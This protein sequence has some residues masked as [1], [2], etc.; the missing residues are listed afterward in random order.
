MQRVTIDLTG[1]RFGRLEVIEKS[2]KVGNGKKKRAYWL[3]QCD[4]GKKHTV[5][6]DGLTSGDTTSCGCYSREQSTTHGMRNTLVYRKWIALNS[7]CNNPK[8][9][10]YS[11]YGERGITV[12]DRWSKF[13]NFLEDMGL[14]PSAKHQIDRVDNEG[15]YEPSNCRWATPKQN[16]NNKRN[17]VVITHN[18]LTMT[19]REWSEYAGIGYSTFQYRLSVG[20]SMVKALNTAVDTGK[21][22]RKGL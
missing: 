6:S 22:W 15:N 10:S 2:P 16:S 18:G 1:D 17:N 9:A 11:D 8:N 13:E 7:R 20:W 4:C 3:C 14:P 19:M 5:R 21:G 12:C